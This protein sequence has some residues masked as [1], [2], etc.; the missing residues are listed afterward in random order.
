[1]HRIGSKR[2]T[3]LE[4]VWNVSLALLCFLQAWVWSLPW[5]PPNAW[6]LRLSLLYAFS[7]AIICFAVYKN[8][9]RRRIL[10]RIRRLL[11]LCPFYFSRSKTWSTHILFLC[12]CT[13][14]HFYPYGF[15]VGF[16]HFIWSF[17]GMAYFDAKVYAFT[18]NRTFCHDCTSSTHS[19]NSIT[20]LAE[21]F[22]FCKW[23]WKKL[24]I[25]FIFWGN[26]V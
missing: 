18:A 11:I 14:V 17:V 22:Y 5:L 4:A 12:S 15:D 19:L 9:K 1:M 2:I 26:G 8:K 20:I 13:I 3:G 25:Y 10:L 6:S 7:S 21:E 16:P 24:N 23:I